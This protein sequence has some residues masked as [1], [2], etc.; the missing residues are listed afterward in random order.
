CV[1]VRGSMVL[2]EDY[3]LDSW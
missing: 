1:R 2:V 3:G